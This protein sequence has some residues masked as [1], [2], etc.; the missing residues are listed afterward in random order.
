M[1]VH[2]QIKVRSSEEQEAVRQKKKQE[3]LD[4]YKSSCEQIYEKRQSAEPNVLLKDTASVLVE[5]PDCFTLWNIRRESIIKFDGEEKKTLLENEFELTK[6]CLASNAKSYCCWFQRQWALKQLRLCFQVN[7]YEKE[8]G[9]CEKYLELDER[10]FHCWAYRFYILENLCPSSEENLQEFYQKELDFLRSKIG[11]NMSNYS[12]WHYR[13]QYLAKLFRLQPSMKQSILASEWQLVLTAVYTDCSDQAAWFYA[14][15]LIFQQM[16][17]ESIN[18][19]QHIRPIE[20]LVEL[21]PNNK[22]SLLFLGQILSYRNEKETTRKMIF[23]QLAE[24]IDPD[25]S[26]FYRDQT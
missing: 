17:F 11:T 16:P 8:L 12:A 13:S 3:K 6:K 7:L 26:Q 15:W 9:L 2:G 4:Q 25:R 20:Q 14:R 23:S 21:E 22:W 5:H 18:E 1:S 10:N 24:Q 19:E